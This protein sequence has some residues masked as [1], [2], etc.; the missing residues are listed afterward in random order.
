MI[1]LTE[2]NEMNLVQVKVRDTYGV[3]RIYPACDIANILIRLTGQKTFSH[4]N[5]SAIRELGFKVIVV[6]Q[7]V[8]EI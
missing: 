7:T 4:E 6:Q 8:E 3:K 2:V 1:L 5:I